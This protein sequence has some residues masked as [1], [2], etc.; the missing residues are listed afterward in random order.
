MSGAIFHNT[1]GLKSLPCPS[2]RNVEIRHNGQNK[3]KSCIR[4]LLADDHPLVRKGLSACL[5]PYE[6]MVI[7]GEADN[8]LEAVAKAKALLPDMVLMDV[9]MPTMSG[10]TATEVLGK[11]LPQVKVLILS[12]YE[13]PD[14]MFRTLQAG[15]RGY[16]VKSASP[17]ELAKA[18][19]TVHAGGTYFNP[20]VT[21][22]AL[23]RLVQRKDDAHDLAELTERE[24]EVLVLVA[25]GLSNKE[26]ADNLGVGIRTVETHRERIM[27][28]LA[29]HSIA[30]LT[31]LAIARGLITLRGG[32]PD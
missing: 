12:M 19:E 31:K 1:P 18:I 2:G 25:E 3:M 13:N 5:K 9:D 7:V 10:L 24:R 26:I 22:L 30:G 21:R 17:A 14:Y 27:R 23:D 16:V 11:E 15:A 32:L 20:E 4:I 6:Q 28:K 8:G 29:V